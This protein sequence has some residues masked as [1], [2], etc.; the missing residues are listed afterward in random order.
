MAREPWHLGP[1]WQLGEPTPKT[2]YRLDVTTAGA[3]LKGST[4]F[5]TDDFVL[6]TLDDWKRV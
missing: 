6:K 5:A 4:A 1:S 3:I 2:S